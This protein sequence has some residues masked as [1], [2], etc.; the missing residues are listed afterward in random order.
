M[1][2]TNIKNTGAL[3]IRNTGSTDS[4][5]TSSQIELAPASTL[6]R[7]QKKKNEVAQSRD[8]S[9]ATSDFGALLH[10][11]KSS[12]GAGILASPDA[13]K[14]GGLI[15]SIFG[16]IFMGIVSTH[17][18]HLVVKASQDLCFMLKKP[19]LCY[20]ETAEAA[21]QEG[22]GKRLRRYARLF[23]KMV[24]FSQFITYYGINTA[25]VLII[26]SS[27]KEI[28]EY[29]FGLSYNI[30]WYSLATTL[31]VVPIGCVKHM[32]Y[33]VPFSAMANFLL[34]IGITISFYYIFQDLPPIDS[35]PAIQSPSS[36]SLFLST[37]LLGMEG[38][39]TIM[40]IENSMRHPSHFLGCPGV[41]NFAMLIV[42]SLITSLG[43]FGYLKYGDKTVGSIT[44]NLPHDWLAESIKICVALAIL[45]T[46]SLQLTASIE[47]LWDNVKHNFN[48]EIQGKAYYVI[49]VL[50]I[51]GTVLLAIAVP[52]LSPV[53]SLIGAVG[54]AVLGITIPV[55]IDTILYWDEGFGIGNWV[56]WK[57]GI[58]L[59]IS[60]YAMIAG[61]IT[62]L[63]DIIEE[64]S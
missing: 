22:A 39:G 51:L 45:F 26:S 3:D 53:I 64:Y 2:S 57:N 50:L 59:L 17:C 24:D 1:A 16:T 10:V 49:R 33:L 25:Y 28:V 5:N 15:F 43:F 36:I 58:L 61:G 41:L 8:H 42:V 56:L 62:S 11:I 37:V 6:D 19:K 12:L 13:F 21:F 46:Y 18:T 40:P 52:N 29:H 32:K 44:L 7:D 55:T 54:F 38:I 60:L 30:R 35:R 31:L 63:I 27:A 4:F 9:K 14:H 23:R 34:G 48:K 20:P 47:V